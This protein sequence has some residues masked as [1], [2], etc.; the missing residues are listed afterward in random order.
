MDGI[1]VTDTIAATFGSSPDPSSFRSVEISTANIPAE[2]GNKLAGVI[3]VNTRSGLE[4]SCRK[5]TSLSGG[6]F[7]TYEGSF[8]VGGRKGKIGYFAGAAGSRT[9]RFRS[10]RA[11]KFQ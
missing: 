11:R 10:A 9:N 6:S 2:Y 7:S 1:P 4:L 5:A 8:N 3:A